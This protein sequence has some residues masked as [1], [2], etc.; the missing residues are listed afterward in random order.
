M[1]L[2]LGPPRLRAVRAARLILTAVAIS[3]LSV[4]AACSGDGDPPDR[5]PATTTRV[6]AGAVPSNPP[7]KS[8]EEAVTRLRRW[9]NVGSPTVVTA[10]DPKTIK[11]LGTET[12]LRVLSALKGTLPP[13]AKLSEEK[14]QLGTLVT[15]EAKRPGVPLSYTGYLLIK[16]NGQWLVEYD[17]LLASNLASIVQTRQQAKIDPKAKTPSPQAVASG[18]AALLRFITLF[19]PG[20]RTGQLRI[21]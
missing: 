5:S 3:A 9:I 8:A 12:L 21:K 11:F 14:T 1:P 4:V 20:P 18:Q 2:P 10:Y 19:A 6:P 7:A 16:K 13:G 15:V 17:G